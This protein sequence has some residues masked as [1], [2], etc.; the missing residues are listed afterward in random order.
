MPK[1]KGNNKKVFTY[2][3]R[4]KNDK[5][6]FNCGNIYNDGLQKFKQ[7]KIQFIDNFRENN[8]I[9]P[10][11]I[12]IIRDN[13]KKYQKLKIGE[14]KINFSIKANIIP[15]PKPNYV[16][17]KKIIN[18]FKHIDKKDSELRGNENNIKSNNEKLPKEKEDKKK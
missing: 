2:P 5:L 14:D 17:V 13:V 12:R 16:Y 15:Q 18:P 7:G 4:K 1:K 8:L 11:Y 9:D 6:S 3:K 10:L